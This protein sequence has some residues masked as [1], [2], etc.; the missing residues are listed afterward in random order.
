MRPVEHRD[1]KHSGTPGKSSPAIFRVYW[2]KTSALKLLHPD[3]RKAKTPEM[4]SRV[5]VLPISH[6]AS[7]VASALGFRSGA[8][9][10]GLIHPNI[11]SSFRLS[12]QDISTLLGLGHFY[13]AL[14]GP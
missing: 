9:P 7:P 12:K 14:T 2:P 11:P 1:E 5:L 13:F 10:R 6:G 4:H 3:G 8:T